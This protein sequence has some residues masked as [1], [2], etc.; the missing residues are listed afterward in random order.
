MAA[1]KPAMTNTERQRVAERQLRQ[2]EHPLTRNL[3]ARQPRIPVKPK[4][5]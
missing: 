3:G 2:Q 4:K 1:K 5:K